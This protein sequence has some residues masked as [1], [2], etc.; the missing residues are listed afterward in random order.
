MTTPFQ[1]NIPNEDEITEDDLK[2]DIFME[3]NGFN[4]QEIQ[5]EVLDEVCSN[6]LA[7]GCVEQ[8]ACQW[9][10]LGTT[11]CTSTNSNNITSFFTKLRLKLHPLYLNMPIPEIGRGIIDWPEAGCMVSKPSVVSEVKK[12]SSKKRSLN[13]NNKNR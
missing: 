2:T 12:H 13:R 9:N 7:L 4:S 8:D 6:L 1:I 3:F 10:A 11:G 5:S